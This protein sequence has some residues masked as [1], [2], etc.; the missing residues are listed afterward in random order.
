M[1]TIAF[2]LR[3]TGWVLAALLFMPLSGCQTPPAIPGASPG[4]LNF[5]QDGR[6]TREE[7]M[8]K[9]GQPSASFEQERILTYRIGHDPAQGYYLVAPNQLRQWQ[10]VRHSLVLV[11]DGGGVLLKHTLV[12][13]Q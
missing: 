2:Y 1:K 5:V 6:T 11:F 10:D 3:A 12:P 4:L 8:L 13:V 9:L 7:I